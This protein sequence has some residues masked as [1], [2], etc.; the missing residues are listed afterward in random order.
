MSS[1]GNLTPVNRHGI[2]RVR[3][4]SILRKASFEET[5]DILY[6]AAV[7]SDVDQLKG[8]SERIV[9]G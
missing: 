8:V 6:S 9:F 2:N 7:F 1:R 4:V 3:D 5:V